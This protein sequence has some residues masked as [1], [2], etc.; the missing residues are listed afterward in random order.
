MTAVS[1][2]PSLWLDVQNAVK[3]A[4]ETI[5]NPRLKTVVL[6]MPVV[7]LDS[8]AHFPYLNLVWTTEANAAQPGS[9]VDTSRNFVLMINCF[10][11]D[12][13]LAE[14]ILAAVKAKLADNL[15]LGETVISCVVG[16][17]ISDDQAWPHTCFQV[18]L[19]IK[20]EHAFGLG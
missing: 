1:N 5:S 3:N 7:L 2:P 9:W 20:F 16:D 10:E 14:Q 18:A 19:A 15:T 4:L 8:A 6:G 11:N 13:P 17:A 12:V